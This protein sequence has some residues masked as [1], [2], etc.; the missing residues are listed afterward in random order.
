MKARLVAIFALSLMLVEFETQRVVAGITVDL[1]KQFKPENPDDYDKY[2]VEVVKLF[3]SSDEDCTKLKFIDKLLNIFELK[4][5]ESEFD[6]SK[7]IPLTI[8]ITNEKIKNNLAMAVH[9]AKSF[10]NQYLDDKR[11]GELYTKAD[12]NS[13]I[14]SINLSNKFKKENSSFFENYVEL[15][16]DCKSFWQYFTNEEMFNFHTRLKNLILHTYK[17]NNSE[18]EKIVSEF[19]IDSEDIKHIDVYMI[20]KK[21]IGN[22]KDYLEHKYLKQAAPTLY[23]TKT[24]TEEKYNEPGE[25]VSKYETIDKG[26]ESNKT[27]ISEFMIKVHSD[28]RRKELIGLKEFTVARSMSKISV[29]N[30]NNVDYYELQRYNKNKAKKHKK[31][32]NVNVNLIEFVANL[33]HVNDKINIENKNKI[34]RIIV[35]YNEKGIG[36]VEILIKAKSRRII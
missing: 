14:D 25:S 31:T 10:V 11:M 23:I 7:I 13:I 18:P 17:P 9:A 35:N 12:A 20:Y 8:N 24:D 22:E 16:H 30:I 28:F 33:V 26:R 5:T 4:R 29:D 2:V 1:T 21:N 3:Y 32:S 15:F 19:T 27:G 34:D 6:I 36:L